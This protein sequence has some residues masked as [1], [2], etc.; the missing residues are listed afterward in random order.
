MLKKILSIAGKPGLYRLVG[1]G[2]GMIIVEALADGKRFP[3]GTRDR[4]SALGDITMYTNGDDE[5]L[6]NILKKIGEKYELKP[7][8]VKNYDSKE[9]LNDFFAEILPNYDTDRVYP[10]DIRK[11]IQW[12]NVLIAAGITDFTAKEEEE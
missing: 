11:L 4:V 9:S 2:K 6:A 7:I 5:P 8:N 10:T 1:R 3:V 12:Y